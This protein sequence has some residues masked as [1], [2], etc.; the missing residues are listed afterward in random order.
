MAD[1]SNTPAR[2]PPPQ[3]LLE[4]DIA[5]QEAQVDRLAQ[6]R[7]ARELQQRHDREQ[8]EEQRRLKRAGKRKQDLLGFDFPRRRADKGAEK[9]K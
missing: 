6:E 7:E 2:K 5:E 3:T 8:S 1:H 4:Q 9:E